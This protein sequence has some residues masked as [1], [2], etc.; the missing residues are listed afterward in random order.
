MDDRPLIYIAGPY[1]KG[2][3]VQNTRRACLLA[4]RLNESGRFFAYVPHVTMLQHF[5][6]P[7]DH[8]FWVD[9]GCALVQRCDAV[10]RM[11]GISPGAD[12]E[13][14]HAEG[15]GIPVFSSVSELEAWFDRLIRGEAG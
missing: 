6:T 5:L 2:D 10:L 1:T 13:T 11:D 12:R 4:D 15:R 7:Q 14:A 3:P 9:Y 8:A